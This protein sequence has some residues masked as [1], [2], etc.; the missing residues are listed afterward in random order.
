MLRQIQIFMNTTK[1][2]EFQHR[3]ILFYSIYYTLYLII[4]VFWIFHVSLHIMCIPV[5]LDL[6]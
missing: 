6:P 5:F 1:E 3:F 2:I 4:T